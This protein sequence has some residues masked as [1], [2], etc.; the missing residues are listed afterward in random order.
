MLQENG[1]KNAKWA[2][3][4]SSFPF[5]DVLFASVNV[6]GK[7]PLKHSGFIGSKFLVGTVPMS[8]NY[9]TISN[10]SAKMINCFQHKPNNK[11]IVKWI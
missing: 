7:S 2:K 5:C 10:F 1:W 6:K 4:R 8:C 9:S 3:T 11:I